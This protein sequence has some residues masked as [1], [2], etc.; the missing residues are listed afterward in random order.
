[1]KTTAAA[2]PA[3]RNIRG[4]PNKCGPSAI[5]AV[6]GVRAQIAAY[7]IR[8]FQGGRA[9]HGTSQNSVNPALRALGW[10]AT[11]H[12]PA[13]SGEPTRRGRAC[14]LPSAGGS[15]ASLKQQSDSPVRQ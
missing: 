2:A 4:R 14:P 11:S 12:V 9:V 3:L 10:V 5:A 15:Q 7:A 13:K 1:M 6:T 8:Q